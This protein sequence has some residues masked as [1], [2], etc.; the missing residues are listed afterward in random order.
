MFRTNAE[1][2]DAAGNPAKKWKRSKQPDGEW[3]FDGSG[4]VQHTGN[5]PPLYRDL[6]P[7]GHCRG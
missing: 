1:P 6:Q 2:N 5:D 4:F 3:R 7:L